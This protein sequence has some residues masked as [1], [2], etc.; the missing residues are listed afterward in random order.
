MAGG[1]AKGLWPAMAVTPFFYDLKRL[2]GNFEI[3]A[4]FLQ[5]GLI[6]RL[7]LL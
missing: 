5:A 4:L 2:L 7:L 3:V 6:H 1:K